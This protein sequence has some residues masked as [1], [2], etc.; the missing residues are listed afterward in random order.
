MSVTLIGRRV[1]RNEDARL[2]TGR[3]LFVDDVHLDGMLHVALLRSDHAHAR[4]KGVDASRARRRPGVVAVY[5][6]EDLGDYWQPGP[7]LVPPPP[8]PGLVFHAATQVPLV[9]DKVRHASEPLALIVA[10]SRYVAEDALDDIAVDLEPLAAVVDLEAALAPG[11]PLVHEHLGSNL[12]AHAHQTKGD[13]ARARARADT[14]IRRRFRYDRGAAAAIENRGIV[15]QWDPRA[16][17]LTLWDT[18]QAPIPIRNGLARM[19][20]LLES[21]VR[22]IAPFVGGGFGPKIMMF[23]PEEVLLPWAAMRL[24]RPLKW[25]EDRRE[26]FYATTQERGQIHDAELAVTRKGRILGVRDAF[27]CDTGA[28]DPYGLTVPINSQCTLL[29]PYEVPSYDSEF[30]VVFTNKTIVTPVRGAGRQHG[31]FVMERLLDLA[32]RELGIDRVEI[33]R[34]NYLPR[35][36][37]PY[38]HEILFQDSAPLVYDSGDYRPALERA[39]ELIGYERFVREEQPR[40]RAAG[41]HPGLGIVSYVEGTGIGPYE[42]ARVTVEP[43]GEVRVATGV[44]TQGQG[45][46]TAFAQLVADV[47]QVPVDRVHV[48]TG[49][50]REFQWGT[51]TFASRGAV[52]AGSA[53]HAAATR[54]RDKILEL[55]ARLLQVD[56]KKLELADGG[57]RVRGTAG[58]GMPLGELALKAN[59]LRGAVRPGTEPGLEATAYFGPDRGSTASG[60]HAMIVEVDPDTALVEIKR[61]VVVHDCGRL[62]NPMIVEGQIQ[63]GVAHGIGNAFY[64]QLVYD[65]SGQLLNASFMD[66]LLPTATDVPR[67]EMDH[68]ETPSPF[69]PTGMKGVGEAGCIPTG[70]AFAQAVEDALA[71]SGGSVEISEIPLSPNRLF[72]LIEQ[73]RGTPPLGAAPPVTL[74]GTARA[75]TIEGRFDF[76]GPREAVWDLLLDPAVL[77]NVMPGAQQ[78]DR[79]GTDGYRGIMKLGVGPISAA[80]FALA[81]TLEDVRPPERY[82]M[83]VDARGALGFVAGVARVSLASAANGDT[84]MTY[85]AA[86]QVGGTLAAVGQRLLDSVSRLM[87]KQGLKALDKELRAR[88]AQRGR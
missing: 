12:A 75:L 38:N 29:G 50:T 24:G 16:E 57:V 65:A 72:E 9:K 52:V 77:R 86:L 79:A 4:L 45:H 19:L 64:E 67:V 88:L 83:R 17:E 56:K 82:A 61:Y 51:G 10:E 70:A 63:G 68:R 35:G 48:V 26:N 47:L 76:H 32:A 66:Y 8:I 33:R 15:A 60:V 1:T 3:A 40:L 74:P 69:N 13:Y 46:F 54:V 55:A 43:S 7:L 58:T 62:I 23:Y 81:V 36:A 30:T 42:G 84:E 18:T 44:G 11:A 22:V 21:Q 85:H 39:A 25:I 31:V 80:E 2:L 14:V 49:D 5:T 41:R 34:R 73:A 6:A 87:S 59:P 28:Y 78:L 27:L 37:F 53:C 20:G 71:G